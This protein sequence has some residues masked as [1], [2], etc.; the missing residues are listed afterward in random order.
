MEKIKLYH[1]RVIQS[2]G[3][4]Y[5]FY[6]LKNAKSYVKKEKIL[7]TWRIYKIEAIKWKK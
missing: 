4:E 2:D 6:T 3:N 1:Y 7:Y 5:I